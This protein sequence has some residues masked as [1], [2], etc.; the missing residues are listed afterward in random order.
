MHLP[1]S[2]PRPGLIV[3]PPQTHITEAVCADVPCMPLH[4]RTYKPLGPIRSGLPA[5]LQGAGLAPPLCLRIMSFWFDFC[6]CVLLCYGC[7]QGHGLSD[8]DLHPLRWQVNVGKGLRG[9]RYRRRHRGCMYT[10]C[11]PKGAETTPLR[12]LND[13]SAIPHRRRRGERPVRARR[14]TTASIQH[15]VRTIGSGYLTPRCTRP[16]NFAG[17]GQ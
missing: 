1:E 16:P 5:A 13:H 4:R 3:L 14:P 17:L 2:K 6:L 15:S 8:P 9:V 10:A 7:R 12:T 11:L